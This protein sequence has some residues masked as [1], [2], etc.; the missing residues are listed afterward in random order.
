MYNRVVSHSFKSLYEHTFD[1]KDVTKSVSR[2]LSTALTTNAAL[3]TSTPKTLYQTDICDN[4]EKADYVRQPSFKFELY[5]LPEQYQ[6]KVAAK[7]DPQEPTTT[8]RHNFGAIGQKAVLRK[9]EAIKPRTLSR[10]TQADVTGT[11][12]A[13]FYPPHYGAHIPSGWNGNRGKVPREDKSLQEYL[14]QYSTRKI[15]YS[16]YVPSCTSDIDLSNQ[17]RIPTTYRELC[18]AVK[19]EPK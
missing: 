7:L 18:D 10:R 6:S 8:Y 14:F 2:N 1:K 13:T 16:G 17:K 12:R 9:Q 11:T 4:V 5:K 3:Y 19:F 15:G